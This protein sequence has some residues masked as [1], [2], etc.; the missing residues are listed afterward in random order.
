MARSGRVTLSD[1]AERLNL[2]KV[3]V[4][5]ALRDHPDIS[6][7]TKERV[8][9]LAQEMGYAPNWLARSL[10]TDKT[11]TVGVIIPK[12]AHNFF[13]D[14]LSGINAVASANEYEIVLCV[15]EEKVDVEQRH[16]RT[17]L[18]MQVDGLLVS[19][20]EETKAPHVFTAMQD[21]GMPL[22]FFDRVID[23]V[24]ASTVTVDDEGG[25]YQ[26]VTHAIER[27]HRKIAHL[28]GPAHVGIGAK[29]RRGYERAL[30][31]YDISIREEWIVEGGFD[32]LN[33]YRGFEALLEADVLP[34]AVFAVTFPVALGAADA[35]QQID[36]SL[37]DRIQ[38]YSFGQHGLN[39][40]FAHPHVSVYQPAYELGRQAVTVL[41]DEI[42]DPDREP[43]HIELPTR[44]VEP[45]RSVEPPYLRAA[46]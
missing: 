28:G 30:R 27:G 14:A 7:Q 44:I 43:Q 32:E 33:G 37:L 17:L 3:S 8:K 26:A 39:R 25:A 34:E 10:A 2:T 19:V 16:L 1:I 6:S 31:D 5:K 29:R 41:L 11:G 35:M 18:S 38:I 36:P 24:S 4:S 22:V 23:G 12:I 40:F 9:Q 15:S 45:E 21:Q 13:A 46:R 20:S 42:D